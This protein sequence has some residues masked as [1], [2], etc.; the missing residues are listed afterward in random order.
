M[1]GVKR[2]SLS[3]RDSVKSNQLLPVEFVFRGAV[4]KG[5]E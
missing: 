2:R 3:L 4:Y 1:D 5:A